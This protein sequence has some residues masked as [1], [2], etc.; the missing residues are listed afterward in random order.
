ME[1]FIFF[2]FHFVCS[3]CL[4]LS[5]LSVFPTRIFWESK[6]FEGQTNLTEPWYGTS[7]SVEAVPPSIIQVHFWTL[8]LSVLKLEKYLCLISCNYF[9]E[10]GRESP[11]GRSTPAKTKHL[12]S[13]RSFIEKCRGNGNILNG[14]PA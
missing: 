13:K 3:L 4:N 7:Y 11:W 14:L 10:M 9:A 5:L 6:N 8:L 12:H 2:A 1:K